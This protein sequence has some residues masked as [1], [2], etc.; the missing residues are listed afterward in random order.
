MTTAPDDSLSQRIHALIFNGITAASA[1]TTKYHDGFM[2]LSERERY[3][4]AVYDELRAGNIEFRLGPLALLAE[5]VE[6]EQANAVDPFEHGDGEP[7]T[8]PW[9]ADKAEPIK[10]AVGPWVKAACG[11]VWS[12][13]RPDGFLINPADPRACVVH[14]ADHPASVS[15]S[16]QGMAMVPVTYHDEKPA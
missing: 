7:C 4:Q 9:C 16:P 2:I 10:V 15:P 11:C 5:A 6:A 12:E 8:D 3:A 13:S 1:V 14:R